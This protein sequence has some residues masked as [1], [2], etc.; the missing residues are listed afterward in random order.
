VQVND[1]SNVVGGIADIFT[2]LTNDG[3]LMTNSG[4]TLS[5]NL[6]STT[7]N[8]NK[9]VTYLSS[10][11]TAFTGAIRCACCVVYHLTPHHLTRPLLLPCPVPS[12]RWCDP[13]PAT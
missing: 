1:L 9:A 7:G 11:I 2:S 5:V 10:A 8:C 12:R 6:A 13:S 3:N 4:A